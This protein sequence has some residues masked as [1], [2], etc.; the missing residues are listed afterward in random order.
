MFHDILLL[1]FLILVA[2]GGVYLVHRFFSQSDDATTNQGIKRVN[3]TQAED[4]IL[5][6]SAAPLFLEA[7]PKASN[8]RRPKLLA[9]VMSILL[10]FGCGYILCQHRPD[11]CGNT[12]LFSQKSEAHSQK[13][14]ISSATVEGHTVVDGVNWFMIVATSTEGVPFEGWV[15]E[16]AIQ[17]QPPKENKVA[18]AMMKKLGLPTNRER[19]ESVKQLQKVGQAIKTALEDVRPKN[20]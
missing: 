4:A 13:A 8:H 19:I 20:D 3:Q 1:I 11:F 7:P 17:N 10:L 14:R 6:S 9:R 2:S 15:S 5:N 16:M 12:P 18:D